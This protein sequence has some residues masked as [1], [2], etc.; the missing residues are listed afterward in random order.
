[1]LLV[2]ACQ[3][4]AQNELFIFIFVE[5]F[6]KQ[7]FQSFR[8]GATAFW[9]LSCSYGTLKCFAQGHYTAVVGFKPWTSRSGDQTSSLKL[10]GQ[11]K[12]MASVM[13]CLTT[14]CNLG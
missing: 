11:S 5:R 13:G 14:P 9:I 2:V 6:G 8:D 12:Y 1:M 3:S 7:F 10:H 4:C